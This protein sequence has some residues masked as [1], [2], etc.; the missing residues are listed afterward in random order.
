MFNNPFNRK[1]QTGG[2]APTDEQRKE[3]EGF[4]A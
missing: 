1:Y 2:S 3:M 4:V